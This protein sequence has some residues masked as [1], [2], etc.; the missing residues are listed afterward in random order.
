M[1]CICICAYSWGEIEAALIKRSRWTVVA[2]EYSVALL[3]WRRAIT[4]FCAQQKCADHSPSV[5]TI[6]ATL[7]VCALVGVDSRCLCAMIVMIDDEIMNDDDCKDD[8]DGK[9]WWL[10]IHSFLLSAWAFYTTHFSHLCVNSI[11]KSISIKWIYWT[12]FNMFSRKKGKKSVDENWPR[13]CLIHIFIHC[14]T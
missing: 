4:V 11:W 14:L 2:W 6:I 10:P 9:W 12:K 3:E 13:Q 5:F 7:W 1:A 8:D